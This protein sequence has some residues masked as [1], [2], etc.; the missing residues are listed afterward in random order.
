LA[1]LAFAGISET[2]DR[3]DASCRTDVECT[4]TPT[5]PET[6][7][8]PTATPAWPV[9]ALGAAPDVVTGLAADLPAPSKIAPHAFL[10]D[11]RI[12]EKYS[13]FRESLRFP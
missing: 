7:V 10:I 6:L 2:P 9:L 4:G 3:R 13:A 5:L 11:G 1:F 12:F 8:A